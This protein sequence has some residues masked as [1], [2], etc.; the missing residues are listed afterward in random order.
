MKLPIAFVS[1][2]VAN[3][4]QAGTGF[5]LG[6]KR[7]DSTEQVFLSTNLG[8]KSYSQFREI[9]LHFYRQRDLINV[10]GYGCYCLNLSDKPLSGI[11]SGVY[12]VDDKDRHCFEFTKKG[13]LLIQ[14]LF[15]NYTEEPFESVTAVSL[16]TTVR[17][18]FQMR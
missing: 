5:A 14:L 3:N 2:A 1:A 13:F 16:L 4:I 7:F 6:L 9:F 12:P 15:R 10:Y 18:A 17:A 11:M 8:E